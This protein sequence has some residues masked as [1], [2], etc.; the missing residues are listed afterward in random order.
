MEDVYHKA[1]DAVGYRAIRFLQMVRRRGGREAAH[2]L[3]AAPAVSPGFRA[4]AKGGRM[5]LTVAALVM[6]PENAGMFT[7]RELGV[8]RSRLDQWA[9]IT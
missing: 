6:R 1:R 4:L 3:L 2:R 5:D 9:H 8:A 7:E